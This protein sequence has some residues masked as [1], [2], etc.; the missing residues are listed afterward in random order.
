MSKSAQWSWAV[1]I[2]EY[3]DSEW[4]SRPSPFA[5]LARSYF[6]KNAQILELGSGAGQDGLWFAKQ[7]LNTVLSDV[8]DTAYE[9]IKTRSSGVAIKFEIVDVTKTL[10]FADN[11][12]DVVYSQLA[13]HYFDD[14]MTHT[15]FKEIKRVLKPR[16]IVAVMVNATTD[17]EFKTENVNSDGLININGLM[18]RY[19][20]TD[21]LVPF[22]TDFQKILL[23]DQGR[24]PKDDAKS[25]NGMIRFIGRNR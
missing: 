4:S 14:H 5:V 11:S 21:S 20:T 16:G 23:D 24:T 1:R 2:K 8:C 18:K 9:E 25:N 12:F 17:P 15:I 3:L 13:L 6:P 19:F 7:G 22:V 10:P